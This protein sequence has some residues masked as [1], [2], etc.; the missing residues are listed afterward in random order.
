MSGKVVAINISETKGVMKK[1]IPVGNFI[2]D[3]GLEG[4]AH[5]GNW[6]RQVSLLGQESIDKMIAMGA[7]GLCD[8]NFSENITN[9]GICVY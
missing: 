2:K 8:C 4:D 6:H 1:P 9:D 3:F 5:A 7:A